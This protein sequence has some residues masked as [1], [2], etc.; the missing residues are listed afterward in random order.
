M[1][2]Y[3]SYIPVFLVIVMFGRLE[4]TILSVQQ[5]DI[6]IFYT[7]SETLIRMTGKRLSGQIPS[8]DT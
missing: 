5:N 7:K 2:E 8:S 1:A 6:K 4:V 3:W